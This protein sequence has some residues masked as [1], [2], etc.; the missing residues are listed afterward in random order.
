MLLL[1]HALLQLLLG[2]GHWRQGRWQ[3]WK[4]QRCHAA[5]GAGGKNWWKGLQWLW[6]C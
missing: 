4:R 6:H 2:V 1:R 5:G 3:G